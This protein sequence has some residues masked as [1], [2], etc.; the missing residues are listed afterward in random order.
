MTK[1]SSRVISSKFWGWLH[2]IIISGMIPKRLVVANV[3][4]YN[5]HVNMSLQPSSYT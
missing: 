2:L 3:I 1:L 5:L 4:Y